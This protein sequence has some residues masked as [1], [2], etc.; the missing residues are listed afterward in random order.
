ME[1]TARTRHLRISPR[2]VRLLLPAVRGRAAAEA[3]ARLRLA[4]QAAAL[5]LSKTIRSAIANAE[6]N[7]S[8]DP[9]ALVVHT[10]TADE[11]RVLK[12]FKP[13]ARGQAKP[14]RRRSSHITVVLREVALEPATQPSRG[15]AKAVAK[16]VTSR[17]PKPAKPADKQPTTDSKATTTPSPLTESKRPAAT[18]KAEPNQAKAPAAAS[19]KPT[20]PTAADQPTPRRTAQQTGRDTTTRR[21]TKKGS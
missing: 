15:R 8:L 14:I 21:S 16:A 10:A 3:I 2:K 1:V 6:H 9:K 11:G 19:R 12:R 20:A 13:A 7:Y 5:P 4:P 18:P 17:A